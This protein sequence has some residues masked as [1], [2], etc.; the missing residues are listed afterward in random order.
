MILYFIL[1]PDYPIL[2]LAL[3]L[4]IPLQLITLL[5]LLPD[6]TPVIATTHQYSNKVIHLV[7][8]L[9]II[10]LICLLHIHQVEFLLQAS[11]LEVIFL[12]FF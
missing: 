12:N 3:H 5:L 6:I 8:L 10:L 9:Q 1:T 2:S 11:S 7:S 4:F